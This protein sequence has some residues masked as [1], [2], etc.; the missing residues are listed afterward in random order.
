MVNYLHSTECQILENP[1][2]NA[3]R[4]HDRYQTIVD[5]L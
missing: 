1:N 3:R 4:V 5:I 2:V